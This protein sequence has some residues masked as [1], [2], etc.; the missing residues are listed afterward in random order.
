M[1]IK[2]LGTGC[3]RCH[4]TERRVMNTL[5]ETG[6][7]ADVQKVTDI[8]E[9]MSFGVLGTPAIVINDKIKSYGRIPT[10]DE[11]KKWIQEENKE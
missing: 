10:T 11:I 4:E 5:A 1:V 2:I 8:K 7:T 3:A 9:I 6:V